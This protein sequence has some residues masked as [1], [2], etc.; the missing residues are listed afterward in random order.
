M[1]KLNFLYDQVTCEDAYLSGYCGRYICVG[2]CVVSVI[3]ISWNTTSGKLLSSL[4]LIR[5]AVICA[6]RH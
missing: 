4:S 1:T 5:D 2:R 6:I 3:G